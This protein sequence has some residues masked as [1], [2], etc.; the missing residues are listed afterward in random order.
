MAA[1][2]YV[3]SAPD[4]QVRVYESPPWNP[5]P[6]V[7]HRPSDLV[8]GQPR[9][10]QLL[11][12]PGPDQGYALLLARRFRDALVLSASEDVDDAIA[13]CVAVANK[14]ASLFG[15]APMIHDLTVAFTLWGF[16]G[17]A[18]PSL[19]A[20]RQELFAAASLGQHYAERR[21]IAAAVPA[22]VLRKPHTEIVALCEV[23]PTRESLLD[24]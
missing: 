2:N 11:G 14:R 3:P 17:E 1:P 20:K 18:H 21:R 6:W 9:G 5:D 16:L 24:F 4:E 10:G 13:G 7:A 8:D 19:V 15:R 22:E 12:N 23:D